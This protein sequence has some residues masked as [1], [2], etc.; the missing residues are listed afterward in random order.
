V[1]WGNASTGWATHMGSVTLRGDDVFGDLVLLS[2]VLFV[3]GA[4]VSLM[5]V[6]QATATSKVAVAFG[7]DSTVICS[8]D[9]C[10]TCPR[11]AAGMSYLLN[12]G[13][14]SMIATAWFVS[15]AEPATLAPEPATLAPEP[16]TLAESLASIHAKEW[17]AACAEEL[18]SLHA[19]NT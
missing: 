16:A 1:P 8:D 3:P 5:S 4:A 19:N 9:V 12:N 14:S 2:T 7:Q 15:V 18:A 17:T 6:P 13:S 10:I 11:T